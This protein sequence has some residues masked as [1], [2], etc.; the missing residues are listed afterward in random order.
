[1][2]NSEMFIISGEYRLGIY[3]YLSLKNLILT[4]SLHFFQYKKSN[5]CK[6]GQ[7]IG[8]F[9]FKK[10]C[11][12]TYTK[13]SFLLSPIHPSYTF[14]Y[15]REGSKRLLHLLN[16]SLLFV[17]QRNCIFPAQSQYSERCTQTTSFWHCMLTKIE[18]CFL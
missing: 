15:T 8:N 3:I 1:M 2:C 4:K 16:S 18:C 11:I 14:K 7:K 9:N 17:M 6:S 10:I 5:N 12:V 13:D